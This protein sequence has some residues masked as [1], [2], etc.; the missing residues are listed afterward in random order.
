MPAKALAKINQ[1]PKKY[2]VPIVIS[3]LLL[4]IYGIIFGLEKPVSFSYGGSSCA[5]QFTLFPG[6]HKVSG[7]EFEVN[8]GNPI[9]IGSLTIASRTACFTPLVT[10][11]V[12]EVKVSTSPFGWALMRKT[13]T[14]AV[15][16]PPVANTQVLNEPIATT[17]LLQIPLSEDDRVFSYSVDINENTASCMPGQKAVECDIPALKLSQNKKYDAKFIRHFRGVN[18]ETL[19]ERSVRT[20]PAVR[21]IKSTIKPSSTIY[22]KPKTITLSLDKEIVTANVSLAYVKGKERLPLT[23]KS[24]VQA[25]SLKI[26]LP[27]LPRSTTFELLV[28]SVEA[29]DGSGFESPYKLGFKTSGGP[30]VTTVSVGSFGVAAGTTAAITFDQALLPEQDTKKLITATG[31]ASIVRKSGNQIFVSLANVPR[32]GNFSIVVAKGVKSKYG[33][34]SNSSWRHN[35]RMVCHTVTTIGYSSEGRPIPAYHFGTGS[36]TV[37]YTGAI[38]GNEYS[39]KLLMERWINELEANVKSIPSNKSVVIIPQINPDGVNSGSRVNARNV[40]LNRNFATN[41]WK[42]DITTVNNTLFPGGGGKTAMSEPETKALAAYIQRIRPV[43]ILSYHSVGSL[44]AA[45]QAG[46]SG[47]LASQYARLSGYRNATG[48][49]DDAFEYSISGTAD[50]WYAQKLGTAS[51]LIELGSH[52]Y[53]QFYTNQQAMWAMLKS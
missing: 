46:S 24:S 23:V 36:R 27:E 17:R 41:D 9:T 53:D 11:S 1:Y 10:P 20:L 26:E 39:T 34:V 40:D 21:V 19:A 42:K 12:G 44:V 30:K 48:Q 14:I 38:H 45:N 50:D 29:V 35:G 3:T 43:L 15:G 2:T 28:G 6:I 22:S 5:R 52:S 4:V 33:V 31:G 7:N 8:Y 13:F 47:S 16:A 32:C 37:V 25:K 51:I 49:S 18:E